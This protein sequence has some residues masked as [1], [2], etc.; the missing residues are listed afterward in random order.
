[1]I[2]FMWHWKR[3]NY[4]NRAAQF[5]GVG[6]WVALTTGPEVMAGAMEMSYL[7]EYMVVVHLHTFASLR[8]EKEWISLCKLY[9]SILAWIGGVRRVG[10]GSQAA[11]SR[12]WPMAGKLQGPVLP[13]LGI[14][15]KIREGNFQDYHGTLTGILK[16]HPFPWSP[17][18]TFPTWPGT[19]CVCQLLRRFLRPWCV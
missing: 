19:W 2:L 8:T 4:R 3:Q 10:S 1:M 11:S 7:H 12:S 14:R 17:F 18:Q 6:V 5:V 9:L 13:L 15:E 16:D